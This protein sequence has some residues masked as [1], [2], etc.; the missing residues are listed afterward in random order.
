MC[1]CRCM[2]IF[3][4]KSI[5]KIIGVKI[6]VSVCWT[7]PIALDH[8]KHPYYY[9]SIK[10]LFSAALEILYIYIY[11]HTYICVYITYN[12]YMHIYT[13]I[14]THTYTPTTCDNKTLTLRICMSA[15]CQ[16]LYTYNIKNTV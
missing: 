3:V 15:L 1:I 13:Y 6:S 2:Y 12:V 7:E 16:V 9:L 14:H 10:I 5:L 11:T 8:S 4:S